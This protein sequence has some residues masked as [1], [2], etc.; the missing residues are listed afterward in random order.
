M[1]R[2][3]VIQ[4]LATRQISRAL[5]V[6]IPLFAPLAA[7]T[8]PHRGPDAAGYQADELA[9][10]VRANRHVVTGTYE[11][12]RGAGLGFLVEEGAA[13]EFVLVGESHQTAETPPLFAALAVALRAHGYDA[14][15]I[16]VGP[17]T[18]SDLVE[19]LRRG[20]I[21]AHRE[22]VARYPFTVPFFERRAEAELLV[23]AL[24]AGYEVWGLD[25]EYIGSGRYWLDRLA[26]LAPD[27]A[28]RAVVAD[29]KRRELAA[30]QHYMETESLDRVLF[31]T[32]DADDFVELRA[33]FARPRAG[34]NDGDDDER[35]EA[36]QII[37]ALAT[38][39]HIYQLWRPRNY[40]N[41]HR[42]VDYMNAN[43]VANLKAFEARA[44]EPAKVLMKFGSYHM[45]RGRSPANQYDLGNLAMQLA[46]YR[47]GES[48]HL[49]ATAREYRGADGTTTAM[50]PDEPAWDLLR[51]QV[52][53][54]QPWTV[55]DLRPLRPYFHRAAN[56][57]GNEGTANWVWNYD[58]VAMAPAFSPASPLVQQAAMND[59]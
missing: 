23:T 8:G 30:A 29:W 40:D 53:Q 16:E 50:G 46:T 1:R 58:V 35:T 51:R 17:F 9:E 41:N 59:R 31:Q 14:L 49:F 57:R 2:N 15:A 19:R 24:D 4:A 12:P 34:S 36:L 56:R 22:S 13:S 3:N 48:L 21:D 32:A 26:E 25:Q 42:R 55:F 37:D 11:D 10:L 43:L 20:G 52:D 27:E 39:A 54:D 28:A 47:G 45:G 7:G 38:S 5:A 44:G 6:V 33:V 18:A